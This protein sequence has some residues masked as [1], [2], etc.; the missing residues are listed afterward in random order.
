[1]LSRIF[2]FGLQSPTVQKQLKA[3]LWSNIPMQFSQNEEENVSLKLNNYYYIVFY[4]IT[5]SFAIKKAGLT[6]P[7][8]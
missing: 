1:M 2:C 8:N 6:L 5:S 4:I 7:T 3:A